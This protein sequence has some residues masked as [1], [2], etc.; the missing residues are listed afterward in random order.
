VATTTNIQDSGYLN[1]IIPDFQLYVRNSVQPA[2]VG[3]GETMMVD[4]ESD[5][6]VMHIHSPS[7]ANYLRISPYPPQKGLP[8]PVPAII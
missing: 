1:I 4:R 7:E 2:T 3:S 6:D 8:D 5:A